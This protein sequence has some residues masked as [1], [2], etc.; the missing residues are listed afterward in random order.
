M[1]CVVIDKV[2]N[3]YVIR[4]REDYKQGCM[5]IEE[6]VFVFNKFDSMVQF[7]REKLEDSEHMNQNNSPASPGAT[8]TESPNEPAR[9]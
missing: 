7:L 4:P 3:G 1:N 6:N 2:V 5:N 9:G 8:L